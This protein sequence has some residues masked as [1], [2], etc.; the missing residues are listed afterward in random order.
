MTKKTQ[1]LTFPTNPLAAMRDL[2]D[3]DA[4]AQE[5]SKREHISG[6]I[7]SK[8][9]S[10]SVSNEDSNKESKKRGKQDLEGR[11]KE[12]ASTPS[13]VVSLRMPEGLND[14][15]DDYAHAH[16]KEKVKKQDLI[17]QAVQL[18]VKELSA[19]EASK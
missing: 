2:Q 14:W 1:S 12:L 9:T 6:N 7:T 11:I 10:Q 13:V 4:Q 16:R 18:L 17:S 19:K 8:L 15:L 3:L 5:A